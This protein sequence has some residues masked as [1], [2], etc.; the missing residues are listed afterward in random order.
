MGYSM[1]GLNKDGSYFT[2]HIT[3]ESHCSYASFETNA[4]LESFSGVIQ[5][6]LTI[7]SPGRFTAILFADEHS[8]IGLSLGKQQAVDREL[9]WKIPGYRLLNL[10]F[11]EFEPGYYVTLANYVS[12]SNESPPASPQLAR[13][14]SL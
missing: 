8:P 5:S 11:N 12:C 9:V 4:E 2:I 14:V 1:N 7:F 10:C 13:Q 3:P 6:N